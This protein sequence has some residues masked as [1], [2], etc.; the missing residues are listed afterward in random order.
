MLRKGRMSHSALRGKEDA[1]VPGAGSSSSDMSPFGLMVDLLNAAGISLRKKPQEEC[2]EGI[3]LRLL[4][5]GGGGRQG[6]LP[7]HLAALPD[8]PRPGATQ[9]LPEP[10]ASDPGNSA[11]TAKGEDEPEED[12]VG[13]LEK[14]E[15]AAAT[16]KHPAGTCLKPPASCL[17][18]PAS[19]L[20]RPAGSS[21]KLEK[22]ASDA[23]NA[24][25]EAKYKAGKGCQ[26]DRRREHAQR[27]GQKARARVMAEG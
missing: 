13:V 10:D 2:G 19:C 16:S 8:I 17:K 14:L 12:A 24:A 5:G 23:Y 27:A 15:A 25:Y 21:S 18:R 11:E 7:G 26:E 22:K 6:T 20:K 3:G 4:Q 9:T 1:V